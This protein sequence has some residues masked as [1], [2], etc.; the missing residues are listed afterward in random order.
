M[1]KLEVQEIIDS[2]SKNSTYKRV[3]SSHPLELYLGLNEKGDPTLRFNGQFVP[4]KILGSNS[5][6]IK[7]VK[8]ST[9]CSILFSFKGNNDKSIFYSLCE[10]L[11]NNTENY[12]GNDGYTELVNRFNQWKKMLNTSS[13]ELNENEIMGLIGEL[14][15]L[16]NFSI[17]KYGEDIALKGWSG[18]EPTHKDF[19]YNNI[20]YE[21]KTINS[22][23]KSVKISSLEQLDS[24]YDGKL[25]VYD[26]EKMSPNYSGV[27]LN[28]LVDE[29]YETLKF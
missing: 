3:S 29:I 9:S 13:K 8:T 22:S 18:P 6:E 20:W 5:I 2:V 21:V 14:L 28:K 12:Y 23:K 16:R 24:I 1:T 26:L 17:P 4:I 25:V 10:D 11:I 15:F 7:Q 27:S 19:S